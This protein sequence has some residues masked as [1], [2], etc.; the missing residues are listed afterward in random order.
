MS[1]KL[2]V[3]MHNF[4]ITSHIRLVICKKFDKRFKYKIQKKYTQGNVY[5]GGT[6]VCS[7]SETQCVQLQEQH[8]DP[9]KLKFDENSWIF[10]LFVFS[11]GA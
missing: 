3:Y 9:L 6:K 7:T 4:I 11:K 10:H 1:C 8:G 2:T 5:D